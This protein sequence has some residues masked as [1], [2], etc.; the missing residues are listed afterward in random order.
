M[1]RV[2]LFT[3]NNELFLTT[4]DVIVTLRLSSH[5]HFEILKKALNGKFL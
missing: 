5:E 4:T 3:I 1:A 2:E